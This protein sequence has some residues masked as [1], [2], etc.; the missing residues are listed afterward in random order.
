MK[1]DYFN[2]V[3]IESLYKVPYRKL[4]DYINNLLYLDNYVGFNDF[5][6][7][8]KVVFSVNFDRQT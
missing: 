3:Q 4:P 8:S 1:W 6:M 2:A 5:T 7:G